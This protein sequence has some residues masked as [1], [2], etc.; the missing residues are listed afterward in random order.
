MAEENERRPAVE[1]AGIAGNLPASLQQRGDDDGLFRPGEAEPD[2]RTSRP[3]GDSAE[4]ATFRHVA[5]PSHFT[6][7]VRNG[8]EGGVLETASQIPPPTQYRRVGRKLALKLT[9]R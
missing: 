8:P 2:R 1:R 6:P 3:Y 7:K 5:H 4:R 9:C